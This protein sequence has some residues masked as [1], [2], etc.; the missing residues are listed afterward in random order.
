M[1]SLETRPVNHRLSDLAKVALCDDCRM[2][3]GTVP[4]DISPRKRLQF[5]KH[6]VWA[7]FDLEGKPPAMIAWMAQEARKY[8]AKMEEEM[9]R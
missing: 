1:I 7:S 6:G 9:L 5:K 8:F 3:D 4:P 2:V